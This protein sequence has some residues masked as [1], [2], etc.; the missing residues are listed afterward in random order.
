M[1]KFQ[2]HDGGAPPVPDDDVDHYGVEVK[3]VL[4]M[5]DESRTQAVRN[6]I[7]ALILSRG[8]E[9]TIAY[10]NQQVAELRVNK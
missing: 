6:S 5:I 4:A 7:R 10:V 3:R 1:P 9:G 2:V 8:I